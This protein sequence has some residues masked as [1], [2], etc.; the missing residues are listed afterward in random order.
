LGNRR[1]RKEKNVYTQRERNRNLYIERE[2]VTGGK[3][4]KKMFEYIYLFI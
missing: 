1:K 4:R 3:Q 2:R